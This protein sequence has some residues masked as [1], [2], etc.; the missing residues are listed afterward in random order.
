M[1]NGE[2]W[3]E[4]LKFGRF[5]LPALLEIDSNGPGNSVTANLHY[6]IE[7][8]A[9]LKSVKISLKD[10]GKNLMFC[11]SEQCHALVR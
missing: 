11:L 8:R 3:P 9:A 5:D 1:S 7:G 2:E 10:N 6:Y 4:E